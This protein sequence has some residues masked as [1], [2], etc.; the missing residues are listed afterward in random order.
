GG[1]VNGLR[2]IFGRMIGGELLLRAAAQHKRGGTGNGSGQRPEKSG[3]LRG[4]A[5]GRGLCPTP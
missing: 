2:E 4:L 5:L 1:A 3:R